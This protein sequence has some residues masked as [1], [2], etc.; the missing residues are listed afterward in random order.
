MTADIFV[1]DICDD[2]PAVRLVGTESNEPVNATGDGN[3]E[4]DIQGAELGT[5]DRDFQSG[6]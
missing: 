3:T 5:D 1:E 4:P 6:N 2:D